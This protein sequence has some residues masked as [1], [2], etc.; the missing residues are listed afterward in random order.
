[1]GDLALDQN[2]SPCKVD[3]L[4]LAFSH[5]IVKNNNKKIL[6]KKTKRKKVKKKLLY[7][8][9]AHFTP[10]EFSIF[11]AFYFDRLR[12]PVI[13]Y[14]VIEYEAQCMTN[15]YI[16]TNILKKAEFESATFGHQVN[17]FSP[18]SK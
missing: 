17:I 11:Q 4:I 2:M 16:L 9:T 10:L 14:L 15:S 1:M 8:K 6:K 18:P 7:L 3:P 5:G 12:C 13:S